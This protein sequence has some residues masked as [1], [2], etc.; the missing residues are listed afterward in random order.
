VALQSA[1]W[2]A[3]ESGRRRG[4][5]CLALSDRSGVIAAAIII[6]EVAAVISVVGIIVLPVSV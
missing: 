5:R 4:G 2:L 6:A 3:S 1:L